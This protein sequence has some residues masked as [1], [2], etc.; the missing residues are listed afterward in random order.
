M[1]NL[2]R[3]VLYGILFWIVFRLVRAATSSRRVDPPEP[4][5]PVPPAALR[6][7]QIQDATFVDIPDKQKS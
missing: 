1:R 4:R 2:F 3:L 6:E 7:D 5:K